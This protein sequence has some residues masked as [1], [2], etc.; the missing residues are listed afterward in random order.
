MKRLLI[1]LLSAVCC[2]STKGQDLYDQC[3]KEVDAILYEA[4]K[5]WYNNGVLYGYKPERQNKYANFC[6]KA[7]N[8][9]DGYLKKAIS[10]TDKVELLWMQLRA[11]SPFLY[12]EDGPTFNGMQISE[13]N[14]YVNKFISIANQ[15]SQY[16]NAI[17]NKNERD[18]E[19]AYIAQNLGYLYFYQ[20]KIRNWR[21]KSNWIS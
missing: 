5:I 10:T 20:K 1:I 15:L 11:L 19:Q 9:I 2:I 4:D 7:S 6:I 12:H 17:S 21:A 8:V 18:L 14:Q 3:S 13:F 16:S